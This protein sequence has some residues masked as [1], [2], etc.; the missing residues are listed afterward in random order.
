MQH[1]P[2]VDPEVVRTRL[3]RLLGECRQSV[4]L[5]LH[6]ECVALDPM[7][8]CRTTSDALLRDLD[9]RYVVPSLSLIHI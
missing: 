2:I 4:L 8:T 6:G 3:S 5:L 1:P 7:L 9:L